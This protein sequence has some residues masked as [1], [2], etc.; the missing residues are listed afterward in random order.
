MAQFSVGANN[1]LGT[2]LAL[3]DQNQQI[4]WAARLDPWGNVEQE[5][6]PNSIDQAIRLPGQ[7]QDTDT[8]LYYNRHR[9]YDPAIGSYV[10]QDP[11]GLSGG[12][13]LERYS[14]NSPLHNIDPLGLNTIAI[15]AGAGAAVGGPPGALIGAAIGL[16]VLIVGAA[17]LAT[18]P[19]PTT[20][21]L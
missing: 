1:H 6:N 12:A 19:A 14:Q 10:N 18:R 11:I 15:G 17:W 2:P 21:N 20:G 5:F 13:N 16:G 8:G 7:H 3:T 9:Y 4:V